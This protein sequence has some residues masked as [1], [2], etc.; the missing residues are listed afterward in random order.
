MIDITTVSWGDLGWIV[1]AFSLS[2]WLLTSALTGYERNRL[3]V[4]E[5]LLRL[6]TGFAILVPNSLVAV[7]ALLLSIA[8]IVGHRYL[9][10]EPS[11]VDAQST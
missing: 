3:F 4:V 7:P 10:G 11:Q 5:R 1:V 2:M 9:N 6:I 8:L